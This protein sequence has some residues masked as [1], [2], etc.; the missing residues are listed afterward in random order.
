VLEP[1]GLGV[2]PVPGHIE[3]RGQEELEQAV[4]AHYLQGRRHAPRREFDPMVGHVPHV[5]PAVVLSQALDHRRGRRRLHAHARGERLRRGP[6]GL[7][8][9]S[10]DVFEVILLG[11]RK[12]VAHASPSNAHLIST[13][14]LV[15]SK[16]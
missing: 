16:S 3:L 1:L 9:Q 14:F 15:L 7:F 5:G 6:S 11:G 2:D 10:V 4:V 8:L 12:R 13:L